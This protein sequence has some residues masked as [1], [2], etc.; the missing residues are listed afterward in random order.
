MDHARGRVNLLEP[1]TGPLSRERVDEILLGDGVRI[2]RVVSRGTSSPE[3]FWYDQ[4]ENEWVAVL[5][6]SAGLRF[7]GIADLVVLITGDH[8]EIPAHTRHRVEWTSRDQDT[9]WL[10]VFY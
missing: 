4:Q 6:G 2:E 5:A 9:I 7:E 8:I 10:A 3:G 1:V